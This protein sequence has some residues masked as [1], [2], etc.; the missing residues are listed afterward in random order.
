M[1]DEIDDWVA[2]SVSEF[3]DWVAG[4]AKH[5]PP[6]AWTEFFYRGDE[7]AVRRLGDLPG[8]WPAFSGTNKVVV[9]G[10]GLCVG[11]DIYRSEGNRHHRVGSWGGDGNE[12]MRLS[13]ALARAWD[14]AEASGWRAR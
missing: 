4:W 14:D 12:A 2:C 8:D 9:D 11:V 7:F 1:S 10:D 3:D 6:G 5:A 13:T